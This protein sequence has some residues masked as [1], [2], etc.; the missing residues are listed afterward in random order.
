MT[1]ELFR[2]LLKPLNIFQCHLTAVL[3]RQWENGIESSY[4]E[5][6]AATVR[7]SPFVPMPSPK[8]TSCQFTYPNIN[9]TAAVNCQLTL[10]QSTVNYQPDLLCTISTHP[11]VPVSTAVDHSPRAQREGIL[12][13][14][15]LLRELCRSVI[16][17]GER[18]RR[19]RRLEVVVVAVVVVIVVILFL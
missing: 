13:P 11:S 15:L 16:E 5:T 14:L 7:S 6:G 4:K 3:S 18:Q 1:S 10:Q 9:V 19:R 8:P 17:Y 12:R 2:W